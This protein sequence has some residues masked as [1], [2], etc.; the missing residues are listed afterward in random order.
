MRQEIALSYLNSMPLAATPKLGEIHGL[1]DGLSAW[2]GADFAEVN[3]LLGSTPLK[4]PKRITQQQAQAYRQVLSMLL[5]Q[6]RPSYLLGRGYDA[7]QNLTNSYLR[8]LDEQGV[9]STALRDAALQASTDRPSRSVSAPA[10][11]MTEKRR[12]TYCV[13]VSPVLWA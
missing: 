13:H 10:K 5:S 9:I 11:F 1:G 3:K 2:F 12:K 6:R 8:L 7:L 4:P